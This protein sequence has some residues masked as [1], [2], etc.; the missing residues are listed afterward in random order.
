MKG[1]V[2]NVSSSEI[3]I[4]LEDGALKNYPPHVLP[5]SVQIGDTI[6]SFSITNFSNSPPINSFSNSLI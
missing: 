4:V 6:N 3:L 2:L 1:T 5:S